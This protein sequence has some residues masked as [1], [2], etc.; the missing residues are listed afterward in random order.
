MDLPTFFSLSLNLAIT[1]SWSEP[2]ISRS[3]FC[4]LYRASP[5]SAAKKYI[6]ILISV[7]TIWWCPCVE[8]SLVLLEENVCYDPCV[9]LAQLCSPLP[10]FIF[11]SKAKLGLLTPGVSWLPAF[12]DL[13]YVIKGQILYDATHKVFRVVNFRDRNWNGGWK[14]LGEGKPGII[15]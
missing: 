12:S 7:L 1:S 15:I 9:L 6:I 5:S 4:W 3:C 8:S 14:G 10:C 11:Y 2:V 13:S